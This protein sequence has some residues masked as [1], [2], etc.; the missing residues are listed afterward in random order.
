MATRRKKYRPNRIALRIDRHPPCEKIE[1]AEK[2]LHSALLALK[3]SVER[4]GFGWYRMAVRSEAQPY[5]EE[6][7]KLTP[8]QLAAM[9]QSMGSQRWPAVKREALLQVAQEKIKDI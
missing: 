6:F 8:G 5:L 7:S 3:S 4:V 2:T 9:V 1:E